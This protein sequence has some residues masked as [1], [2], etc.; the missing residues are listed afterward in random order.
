MSNCPHPDRPNV[1]SLP[2]SG[3]PHCCREC[4]NKRMANAT[5]YQGKR[6]AWDHSGYDY[7]RIG[8]DTYTRTTRGLICEYPSDDERTW[9]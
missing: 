9:K 3:N 4:W 1:L 7:Q 2:S 5:P 6:E 8:N